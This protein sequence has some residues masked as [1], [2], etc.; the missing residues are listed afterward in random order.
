MKSV[1][2]PAAALTAALLAYDAAFVRPELLR[3]EMLPVSEA[4]RSAAAAANGEENYGKTGAAETIAL[5]NEAAGSSGLSF[6]R[7]R[8]ISE[9]SPES[10]IIKIDYN[11][12]T[13]NLIHLCDFIDTIN[14]EMNALNTEIV[15]LSVVSEKKN[16]AARPGATAA[17]T[18][19]YG[20]SLTVARHREHTR[21]LNSAG[22]LLTDYSSIIKYC[23]YKYEISSVILSEHSCQL[24]LSGNFSLKGTKRSLLEFMGRKQFNRVSGFELS[25]KGYATAPN[26][27]LMPFLLRIYFEK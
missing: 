8:F 15:S 16:A 27:I 5:I 6:L 4:V 2:L 3:A 11:F 19:V 12:A 14:F 24:A 26:Q 7:L 22:M 25:E 13:S 10:D 9:N 17:A 18:K 21:E 1:I 23:S 20:I